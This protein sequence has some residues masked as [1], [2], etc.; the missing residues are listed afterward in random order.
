MTEAELEQKAWNDYQAVVNRIVWATLLVGFHD[1]D[2]DY[3]EV[4]FDPPIP[5]RVVPTDREMVVRWCC[6]EW[7]DPYYAVEP[8]EQRPEMAAYDGWELYGQSLHEKEP[9]GEIY[10]T[11]DDRWQPPNEEFI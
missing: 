7:L 2:E 10:H 1:K 4:N 6:N 8:L 9:W 5:V 3:Y 11:I